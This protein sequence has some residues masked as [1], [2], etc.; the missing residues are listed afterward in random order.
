M[1]ASDSNRKPL[2][3]ATAADVA[4]LLDHAILHPTVTRDALMAEAKRAIPLGVASL[5]VRPGDVAIVA[6]L[7]K[8]TDVGVGTVIGFPHG[9][10]ST[11]A[12]VTEAEQALK[13][14]ADELDMVVNVGAALGGDWDTVRADIASVLGVARN[15]GAILKVIFETDYLT[16]DATKIHLCE[17]CSELAV[18]F[19]KTST[20]FGYVKQPD[21]GA[22]YTGATPHD[23]KLMAAHTPASM[24]IKPSG[25][26][27]DL[28]QALEFVTLGAT[29]IGTGSGPAIMEQ[30][31]A[32]FGGQPAATTTPPADEPHAY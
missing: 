6:P 13:D 16:E 15:G 26:I 10:T 18:D 21:G 23:V 12:K 25:G 3:I 19:V 32:R 31:Y 24:G 1:S 28:E 22:A 11:A 29:R 2:T 5:C 4:R 20:G 14:G 8:D 17:I 9:T 30:A 7:C 27:R